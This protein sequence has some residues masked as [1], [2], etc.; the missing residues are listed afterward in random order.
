MTTE[1]PWTLSREPTPVCNPLCRFFRCTKFLAPGR[2]ALDFKRNPPWCNWV[3]GPCIGFRCVYASCVQLKLLPDGR[4]SLFIKP[5]EAAKTA[6]SHEEVPE[7]KLN[8][9]GRA[10]K[11]MRD[12]GF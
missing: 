10:G 6:E 4:C 2:P 11:R 7:V 3:D 9:R 8:L 12:L 5:K 1:V